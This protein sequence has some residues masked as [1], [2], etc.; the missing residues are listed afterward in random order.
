[1]A[2]RPANHA[3]KPLASFQF[4]P[5]LRRPIPSDWKSP[6]TRLKLQNL[7]P[8]V[9]VPSSHRHVSEETDGYLLVHNPAQGQFRRWKFAAYLGDKYCSSFAALILERSPCSPQQRCVSG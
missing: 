9:Q 6:N 2:L 5:A 7:R 1:M 4:R 3:I 8:L